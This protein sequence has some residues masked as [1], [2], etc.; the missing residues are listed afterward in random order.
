MSCSYM[1]AIVIKISLVFFL[2]APALLQ[3]Q[4]GKYDRSKEIGLCL[5][6][7]YYIGDL[8]PTAHF[9]MDPMLGM[10]LIYRNNISKRWTIKGSLMR[11]TFE[12]HDADSDDP[13][14]LNR[15]LSVRN[16][17]TEGALTVELNYFNYQIGNDRHPISPYVFGGLAYYSHKPQAE[18]LGRFYELQ[19]LGT[20]GQGTSAGGKKYTVNGIAIPFG[21]G[22][23]ANLFSIVAIS[24]EWGMRK[25]YTDYL[26]DVSG[27]YANENVLEDENGELS[28]I[29]AD[30]SFTPQGDETNEGYQ[31]GDPNRRDWYNFTTLTLAVRLGKEPTSCES[32]R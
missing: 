11:G 31:R 13:F 22:V 5:N 29:L 15:N 9:K 21:L 25:T 10:G 7:M 18:Y 23:K 17:I 6:T 1:R 26:D 12:A 24:L 8:N 4:K 3:A 30:L 14:Q 28:A 2:L 19:P 20:E 27:V 16:E 32:F